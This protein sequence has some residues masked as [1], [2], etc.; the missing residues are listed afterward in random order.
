MG[1][2]NHGTPWVPILLRS[3]TAAAFGIL[4]VFWQSPGVNVLSIAGGLYLL[5]TAVTVWRVSS[6]AGGQGL[7]QVRSLQL[8]EAAVYAVAGL[9]V[10]ALR[11]VE[12]FCA[13][14]GAA[15]LI[16]GAVE[17]YLWAK[18][19]GAFLP[20]RDWL[21][22]GVVSLGT[23]AILVAVLAMDLGSH[24]MLGVSG[25]SAIILA[26]VLATSGLGARWDA[27]SQGRSHPAA[28]GRENP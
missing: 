12:A 18:A 11:S 23:A 10:L 24:A 8:L 5:L 9:A 7:A 26:V 4:T 17:L 15:L 27:R 6:L 21:I 3:V 1:D 14:A 28:A 22:T 25:G 19:R 20:A 16:G 13:A 2:S